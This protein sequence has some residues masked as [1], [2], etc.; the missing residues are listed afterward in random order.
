MIWKNCDNWLLILKKYVFLTFNE[1]LFQVT[2]SSENSGWVPSF[3]PHE[4][5]VGIVIAL[6]LHIKKLTLK[7][8]Q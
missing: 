7:E 1:H 4:N 6:T 3:D 5:L 8:D 2:Q